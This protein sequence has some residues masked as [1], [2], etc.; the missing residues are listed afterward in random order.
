MQS[1][2]TTAT[3][4]A[5]SP[6]AYYTTTSI[7]GEILQAA[8]TG[9]ADAPDA[10]ARWYANAHDIAVFLNAANPE[11]WPLDEMDQ[12]L[13]DHLDATTAEV[14]ARLTEDW[15]GDVAA[16]ETVHTGAR[17]GRHAE[18]RHHQPFPAKFR[19]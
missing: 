8:K 13:R 14:V 11:N 16:Y 12:M 1:S 18:R 6:I 3:R 10:Q 19:P 5:I 9:D 7:A 15:T 4:P 2:R 17:D